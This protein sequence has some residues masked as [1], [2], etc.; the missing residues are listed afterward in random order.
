M[1]MQ[2]LVDAWSELIYFPLTQDTHPTDHRQQEPLHQPVH[3]LHQA[4]LLSHLH[5]EMAAVVPNTKV[6]YIKT[7]SPP[8]FFPLAPIL[9]LE[10][11][12]LPKI[13]PNQLHFTH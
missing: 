11:R 4:L 12:T 1:L 8:I 13:N 6:N 9:W 3:T 5:R 7:S 10:N 2:S